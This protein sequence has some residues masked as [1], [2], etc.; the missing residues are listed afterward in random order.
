[1]SAVAVLP[2]GFTRTNAR[3]VRVATASSISA[4]R[5]LN[6]ASDDANIST[7]G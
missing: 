7:S 1:M 4:I 3:R 5:R 2:C 6:S